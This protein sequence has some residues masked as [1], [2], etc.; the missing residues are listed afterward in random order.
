[1][2][3]RIQSLFLLAVT[4]SAF[5]I[6]FHPIA[7]MNMSDR[8]L[9]EFTSIGLRSLEEPEGI[10]YSAYPIAILAIISAIMSFT[11][12]VLYKQR[13]LQMRLCGYNII[14]TILLIAVVFFYYFIL[15]RNLIVGNNLHIVSK[16]FQYPILLPFVNI[17][18]LFQA[19]RAIR[20]DDLLIKS[21]DRLRD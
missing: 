11:T 18:L 17:I 19:F 8:S 12:L 6:V 14:L 7:E 20:R 4:V 21:Y 3:Q 16:S 15:A 2:I 10:L 1:M 13:L 9:A 5:L